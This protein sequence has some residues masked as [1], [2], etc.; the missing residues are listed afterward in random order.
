MTLTRNPF[1]IKLED[2]GLEMHDFEEDFLEMVNDSS[3]KDIFIDQPVAKFWVSIRKVHPV[4]SL[5]ALTLLIGFPSTYLSESAFSAVVVI[6]SQARNRLLNMGP[7]FRC[8]II[9]FDPT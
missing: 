1:R 9:K 3:A 5:K 8:E 4:I 2:M 7:D 6:K